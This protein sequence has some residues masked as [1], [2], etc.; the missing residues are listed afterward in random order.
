MDG[1]AIAT[2]SVKQHDVERLLKLAG[3]LSL[4]LL[5]QS[6]REGHKM[7]TFFSHLR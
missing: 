1:R 4:A 2:Q 3:W 7:K 5:N 6:L